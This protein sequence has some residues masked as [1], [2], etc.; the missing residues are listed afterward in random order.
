MELEAHATSYLAAYLLW[1]GLGRS[2]GVAFVDSTVLPVCNLRRA[3]WHRVFAGLAAF[4][5]TGAGWFFGFKLHLV[6]NDRGDLLGVALTP[7]NVDDRNRAVVERLTRRVSGKLAGDKG[8]LDQKL[9]WELW[10]QNIELIT[11]V[12]RN[13]KNKL[14]RLENKFVYRACGVIESINHVLKDVLHIQHT[15]YR[16]PINFL[17]NMFAGLCAYHFLEH[18][19][20]AAVHGLA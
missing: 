11:M 13:M 3:S 19:P 4:G 12:R 17:S 1:Q 2:T 10:Q 15:R 6:V 7:G 18:K 5:K 16:S 20:S 14:V 9:F 8:Y